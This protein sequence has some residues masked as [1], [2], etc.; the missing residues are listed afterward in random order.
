[1][2][3]A[4]AIAGVVLGLGLAPGGALA[5][6]AGQLVGGW[7]GWTMEP[8]YGTA[9]AYELIIFPDGRYSR[10]YRP[11]AYPG[12]VYDAGVWHTEGPYVRFDIRQYEVYPERPNDPQP[13]GDTFAFQLNGP[14]QLILTIPSCMWPNPQ[15]CTV[16]LQRTN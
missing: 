5:Q 6:D 13:A 1:M 3:H 4:A 16:V 2:K 8:A 12:G 15:M 14:S 10:S 11:T 7:Q 9:A